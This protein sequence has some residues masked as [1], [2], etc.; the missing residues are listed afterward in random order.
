M[1]TVERLAAVVH[2][3]GVGRANGLLRVV[4][5][6]V[7][8]DHFRAVEISVV[9][10]G[11]V[12]AYALKSLGRNFVHAV[13]QPRKFLVEVK[14]GMVGFAVLQRVVD[15]RVGRFS[16]PSFAAVFKRG[17]GK[18][19]GHV[20]TFLRER[21]G[22]GSG[23]VLNGLGVSLHVVG[24]VEVTFNDGGVGV[25]IC[26]GIEEI[27]EF[28]CLAVTSFGCVGFERFVGSGFGFG[29]GGISAH[30]VGHSGFCFSKVVDGLGYFG[31]GHR[32]FGCCSFG[33]GD[34]RVEFGY[35]IGIGLH[36]GYVSFGFGDLFVEA[37]YEGRGVNAEV[38]HLEVAEED[39][40]DRC[41][42]G[43][44]AEG[45][46]A[47]GHYGLHADVNRFVGQ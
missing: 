24:A 47:V 27:L 39:E 23:V 9:V 16:G 38:V 28:G 13:G 43:L 34:G 25:A 46:F 41:V 7:S 20:C 35:D 12:F 31:F 4:G 21:L 3:F 30:V 14:D 18:E 26:V 1:L 2:R 6:E 10:F 33:I 22:E 8:V 36:V 11:G 17:I 40:V 32:F 15:F 37:L 42:G 29:E 45:E 19:V 44:N 5:I